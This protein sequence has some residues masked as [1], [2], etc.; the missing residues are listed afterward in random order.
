YTTIVKPHARTISIENTHNTGFQLMVSMISHC[1][2]FLIALG[3][4][5]HTPWTYG[6]YIS[7]IGFRLRV[8]RWIA[9]NFRGGGYQHTGTFFLCQS[10]QMVR[11]HGSYL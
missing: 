9:I 7:P 4:I 6:V 3:F 11:S 5:V 2:G 10:Q 1:N 8:Y